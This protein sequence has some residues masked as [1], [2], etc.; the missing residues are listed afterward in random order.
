MDPAEA[1]AAAR[2]AGLRYVTDDIP[3]IRRERRGQ[4]FVYRS[5]EGALIRDADT[6]ARI[7]SLAVPPAWTEVWIS[8]VE[9]G[10]I[11]ATGRDSRRRKQYR[12]HPRW[13]EVRDENKYSRMLEFARLLPAVR[14]RVDRDLARPG[15]PRE[16][17][18]A[19]V[20]KLLETTLARVGNQEYA[21]QNGSYGLTTLR[22]RHARVK[23]SAVRFYFRGKSGK[24][25]EVSV[26]SRRL[27]QAIKQWQDL[28]GQ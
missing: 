2:E 26:R 20:V 24:E 16:K 27:A 1:L 8:P 15:L 3:G 11:Q 23:G 19:L 13:R 17:V 6:L 10:H 28:P 9:R 25:H 12:Y 4:G 22:D 7:R 21:V 14:R 18:L 5:P